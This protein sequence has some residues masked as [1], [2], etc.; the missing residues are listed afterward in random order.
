MALTAGCRPLPSTHTRTHRRKSQTA[1]PDPP[2]SPYLCKNLFFFHSFYYFTL[3]FQTFD[4]DTTFIV[5]Y[6]AQTSPP[7]RLLLC[8]LSSSALYFLTAVSHVSVLSECRRAPV[9]VVMILSVRL[10]SCQMHRIYLGLLL[11]LNTDVP[12]LLTQAGKWLR[13]R[14]AQYK[15]C[16]NGSI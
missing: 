5:S 1:A 7:H 13:V 8:F 9:L 10:V 11:M 2:H 3:Y 15:H 6:P 14:A 16:E 12:A 4:L